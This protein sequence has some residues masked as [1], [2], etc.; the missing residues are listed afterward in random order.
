MLFISDASGLF[1]LLS[2]FLFA[3]LAAQ[4]GPLLGHCARQKFVVVF[5]F[6]TNEPK[7]MNSVMNKLQGSRYRF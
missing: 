1:K 4:C 5:N 7:L 3:R 2:L 6:I